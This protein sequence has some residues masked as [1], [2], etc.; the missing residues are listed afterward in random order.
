[1]CFTVKGEHKLSRCLIRRSGY[2]VT[3][4]KD[5]LGIRHEYGPSDEE[6]GAVK[7]VVLTDVKARQAQV[8]T[9]EEIFNFCTRRQ[10][11]AES[12]PQSFVFVST[13]FANEEYPV[14]NTSPVLA[15]LTSAPVL[16]VQEDDLEMRYLH[17]K[18]GENYF[19]DTE[20]IAW[21][22]HADIVGHRDIDRMASRVFH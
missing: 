20:D 4:L 14:T 16:Q 7:R 12:T 17:Q 5:I 6:I 2:C 9:A 18:D 10:P 1:M 11:G 13:A 19:S 8:L 15:R 21:I 3:T 22:A